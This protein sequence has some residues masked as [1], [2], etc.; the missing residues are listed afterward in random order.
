MIRTMPITDSLLDPCPNCGG[1]E[2]ITYNAGHEDEYR[3]TCKWCE[4][5]RRA[6]YETHSLNIQEHS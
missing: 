1:E 6:S 2:V 4:P 5:T 3:E